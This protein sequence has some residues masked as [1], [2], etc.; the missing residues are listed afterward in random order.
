[1]VTFKKICTKS[2]KVRIL[3][4]WLELADL[5]G[6][7]FMNYPVSKGEEELRRQLAL[8]WGLHMHHAHLCTHM[9]L[10]THHKCME[11]RN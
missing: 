7:R 6:S 2:D 8:I 1:M 11:K 3:K 5:L 9:N 4:T 10:Y